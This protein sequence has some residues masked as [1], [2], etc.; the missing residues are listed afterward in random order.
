[1]VKSEHKETIQILR[2]LNNDFYWMCF[3]AKVGQLAH[4][5]LEFNGLMAK[6]IDILE[7]SGNDPHMTSVHG[8][9]SL[10]VEE[11]DVKYLAEKFGCIF[12]PMFRE[13]PG[14][15]WAFMEELGLKPKEVE[16]ALRDLEALEA[17]QGPDANDY[18][19]RGTPSSMECASNGCGF[20]RADLR[21]RFEAWNG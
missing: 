19:E 18:P 1:M 9:L 20:C 10:P 16:E 5:F 8:D 14:L 17:A 2:K 21:E 3:H 11:H 4:P 7:K 12:A 6:Y 15:L 13:K